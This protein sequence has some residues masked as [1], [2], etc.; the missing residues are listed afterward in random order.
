[1]RKQYIIT[2]ETISLSAEFDEFGNEYSRVIEGPNMFL[3]A[4]SPLKIIEYTLNYYCSSLEGAIQGAKSIL[5]E[6]YCIPIALDAKE[7]III[8]PCGSLRRKD[9]VWIANNQI[10]KLEQLGKETIIH[11]HYGH[12]LIVPM[13]ITQIEIKRGQASLLQTTQIHRSKKEMFLYYD[14]EKGIILRKKQGEL[15][16]IVEE[17]GEDS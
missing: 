5:G 7:G 2:I 12:C 1:M 8:F 3:V 16:M 11:T 13:K 6:K 4:L 14:R 15:N 9:S 17:N 10:V